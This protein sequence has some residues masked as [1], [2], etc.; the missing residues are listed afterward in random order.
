MKYY[1]HEVLQIPKRAE[2]QYG[3]PDE[4]PMQLFQTWPT[5]KHKNGMEGPVLGDPIPALHYNAI[6][7]FIYFLHPPQLSLGSR[8]THHNSEYNGS[9]TTNLYCFNKLRLYNGSSTTSLCIMAAALPACIASKNYVECNMPR[10]EPF[11]MGI[12]LHY[13][14][15]LITNEVFIFG[16]SPRHKQSGKGFT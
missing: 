4:F 1:I 7:L 14:I 9:S 3:I 10:Q 12:V 15:Y 16:N 8:Y 2:I 13:L 11:S 6:V 5:Q